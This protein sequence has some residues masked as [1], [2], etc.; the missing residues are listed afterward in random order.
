MYF[1]VNRQL[2]CF[3][4]LAIVNK[5]TINMGIEISLRDS[6]FIPFGYIPSSQMTEG[7]TGGASGK[8]PTCQCRRCQKNIHFLG[9]EDAL[10]VGLATHSSIL[11]WKIP[12][13]EE[14]GGLRYI[15]SQ[16]V[17]H[18]L[19]DLACVHAQNGWITW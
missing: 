2:G 5:A 9:W 10:E 17:R 1:S 15:G 19:S 7:F 16:R 12:W 8:E 13:T 3:H 18:N 6:N 14:S 11:A 4:V